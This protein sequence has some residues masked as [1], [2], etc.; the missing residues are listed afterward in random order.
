MYS[1]VVYFVGDV[2][3]FRTC[4]LA[5][6]LACGFAAH[7]EFEPGFDSASPAKSRFSLPPDGK[8]A[9]KTKKNGTVGAF[10]KAGR[11]DTS[12]ISLLRDVSPTAKKL[13]LSDLLS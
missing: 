13:Y 1:C 11:V 7:T 10:D 8:L 3:W 9:G 4:A 2:V 6:A 12:C 5:P